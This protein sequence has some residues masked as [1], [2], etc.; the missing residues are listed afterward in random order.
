LPSKVAIDALSE[1][2][3][4]LSAGA[5]FFQSRAF[6]HQ[7]QMYTPL[8][9][10]KDRISL[11]LFLAIFSMTDVA[12]Q[13]NPEPSPGLSQGSMYSIGPG[14]EL[15]LEGTTNVSKF[16]C[17]CTET[18]SP[19]VYFTT[20]VNNEECTIGFRQT[21]LN[22]RIDAFD[23][24]N[25]MMNKDMRQAL[26]AEEHPFIRIELLQAME[27]QCDG[28]QAH[29]EVSDI[30]ARV[31]ITLNGLGK[32]Y[33]MQAQAFRTGHNRYRFFGSKTLRMTDFGIQP[34][35][36]ALGVIKV[37]DDIRINMNLD[38]ILE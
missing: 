36:A 3:G 11:L 1:S 9:Y 17:A 5:S 32:E 7:G 35:T 26:N 34:P 10:F 6:Y 23:C 24:G 12:A 19:Q 13:Y 31:R 28:G 2:S 30:I 18:F 25:K 15:T 27:D 29:W 14:S 21:I 33:T 16:S 20:H 38:V 4:P 8:Q 22:L 37:R